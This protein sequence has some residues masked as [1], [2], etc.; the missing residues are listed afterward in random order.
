MIEKNSRKKLRKVEVPSRR[1]S[2]DAASK[3]TQDGC[4]NIKQRLKPRTKEESE[5]C[6]EE[7]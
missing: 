2:R 5:A 4:Q 1:I 6:K 7:R 3:I